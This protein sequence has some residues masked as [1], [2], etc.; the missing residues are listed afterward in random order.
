MIL[1]KNTIKIVGTILAKNEEDIIAAN[2]EHHI[3]HGVSQIILTDNGSTD[4]TRK[5]ASKY[6]EVVEI[7]DEPGT[8]HNQSAWVTR[9]ARLACKLNPDWIVHFDADELWCGL[10]NLNKIKEKCVSSTGVYLHPPRSAFFS[11]WEMRFY[12]DFDDITSLPGESKVA[13][14][15]DPDIVITH[16]NHG[17]ENCHDLAHT[18]NIW[19][20]H[21]PVRSFN[22]FVKKGVSGHQALLQRNAT[23][24]RWK[25]WH[26][27][28][29]EGKLNDLYENICKS[30]SSMIKTPNKQD[31]LTLIEFWATPAIKEFFNTTN[32]LPK[33]G[34]WPRIN[35][36]K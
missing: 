24:E 21:F 32:F 2:I 29:F 1:S 13:H 30:W 27:L 7:I 4:N 22:Q 20:H 8:D 17:F 31:F 34:E 16:G 3:N 10:T 11:L 19:R 23:C 25:L 26:D 15:P 18:K 9:M 28:Y 6:P 36:E 35:Y 5:I 33:I 14:R 12:L